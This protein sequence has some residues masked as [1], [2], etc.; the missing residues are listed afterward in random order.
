MAANW[1]THVVRAR[2]ARKAKLR[3]KRV[4]AKLRRLHK[5][6]KRGEVRD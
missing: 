6:G 2:S 4:A 3:Q 1:P 5:S